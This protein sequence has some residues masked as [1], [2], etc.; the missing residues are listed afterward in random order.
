MVQSESKDGE[1]GKKE[2][3]YDGL[4][5][6][7]I[8]GAYLQNDMAK[9]FQSV[10]RPILAP[11]S[12]RGSRRSRTR[13]SNVGLRF[14]HPLGEKRWQGLEPGRPDGGGTCVHYTGLRRAVGNTE[15]G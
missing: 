14:Y 3:G 1:L 12:D 10:R 13:P 11:T 7:A 6:A 2:F 4:A 9:P 8:D 5:L 15:E